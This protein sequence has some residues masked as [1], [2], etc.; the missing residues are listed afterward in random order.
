LATAAKNTRDARLRSLDE[1]GSIWRQEDDTV[2]L[3]LASSSEGPT[4]PPIRTSATLPSDRLHRVIA[5]RP[6]CI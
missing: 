5:K 4:L 6:R 3:V 2:L 1:R